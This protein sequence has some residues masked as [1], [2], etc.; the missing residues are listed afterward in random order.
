MKREF[1][2]GLVLEDAS[3]LTQPIDAREYWPF[4]TRIVPVNAALA[5]MAVDVHVF[6]MDPVFADL[7][8]VV[9]Y[10]QL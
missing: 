3:F 7:E 6:N 1:T 9:W 10:C 4:T 5:W 2:F 8:P